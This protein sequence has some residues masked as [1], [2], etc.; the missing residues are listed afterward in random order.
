MIAS[1]FLVR[2]NIELTPF[3]PLNSCPQSEHV[4]LNDWTGPPQEG[5]FFKSPSLLLFEDK[6][7][8]V[9]FEDSWGL[10]IRL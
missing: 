4:V 8:C 9:E 2:A 1:I 7:D 6:F 3:V 5:H 10:V